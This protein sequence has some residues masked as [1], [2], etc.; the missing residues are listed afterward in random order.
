MRLRIEQGRA[1]QVVFR[2]PKPPTCINTQPSAT[3]LRRFSCLRVITVK[4]YCKM[5]AGS[6]TIPLPPTYVNPPDSHVRVSNYPESSQGVTPIQIVTLNRRDK[7]N[8]ITKNM[9]D[10]LIAYYSTVDVDDRVKVVV[11][12][13]AGKAFSAG[14]D[15]AGDVSQEKNRV[16]QLVLPSSYGRLRECYIP[17]CH[18]EEIPGAFTSSEWYLCGALAR[19]EGCSSPRY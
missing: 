15:L 19:A 5:V 7:L 12:T 3:H 11:L 17:A 2:G 6:R 16:R 8:A 14:I 1:V 4:S 9:I 10:A 18:G 13:G